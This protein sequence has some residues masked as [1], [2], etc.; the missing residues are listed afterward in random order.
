MDSIIF[1]R[2]QNNP[3][4]VYTLDSIYAEHSVWQGNTLFAFK[5]FVSESV[6]E[7]GL[8]SSLQ[9]LSHRD[10]GIKVSHGADINYDGSKMLSL[11]LDYSLRGTLCEIDLNSKMK[12][13][14][15]QDSEISRGMYIPGTNDVIYYTDGTYYLGPVA[16]TVVAGYY[17]LDRESGVTELL[18]PHVFGRGKSEGLNSFD[19]DTAQNRLYFAHTAMD[20]ELQIFA[21]DIDD[22]SLIRIPIEHSGSN[23][24][25]WIDLS[26]DG[27][28][29]LY[30]RYPGVGL[31]DGYATSDV[32]ILDLST[33]ETK[34]IETWVDNE[35]VYQPLFPAWSDDGKVISVSIGKQETHTQYYV[36]G[37]RVYFVRVQD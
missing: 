9:L 2:F 28:K 22:K 23:E 27:K 6:R 29:L 32:N 21:Y 7:Y 36:Y 24:A 11:D 33:L 14:I 15:V 26:P 1:V 10:Y 5:D 30:S 18:H 20:N 4:L 16:D 35:W 25:L 31:F 37:F 13:V 8:D 12:T 34:K 19:I 17:R 3:E